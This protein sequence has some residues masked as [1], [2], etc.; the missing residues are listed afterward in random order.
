MK[1]NLTTILE[2]FV[3]GNREEAISLINAFD[4]VDLVN[5]VVIVTDERTTRAMGGEPYG[6]YTLLLD[7]LRDQSI[8]LDEELSKLKS[9]VRKL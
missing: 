4:C 7:L 2:T 1:C 8:I 5:L 3:N 9:F 6:I